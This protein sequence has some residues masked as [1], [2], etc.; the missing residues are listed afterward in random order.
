[1]RAAPWTPEQQLYILGFGSEKKNLNTMLVGR[2]GQVHDT[3]IL[4]LVFAEVVYGV[5]S[6]FFEI[7]EC[8]EKLHDIDCS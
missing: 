6:L 5:D 8:P 1:M 4:I 3:D 7:R 2:A